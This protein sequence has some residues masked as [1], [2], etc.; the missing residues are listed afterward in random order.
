MVVREVSKKGGLPTCITPSLLFLIIEGSSN[1][2]RANFAVFENGEGVKTG[3]RTHTNLADK[4]FLSSNVGWLFL[5][6][7]FLWKLLIYGNIQGNSPAVN[8]KLYPAFMT[9]HA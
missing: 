8:E 2:Y 3:L 5:L 6:F 1:L 9:V 4:S 7:L